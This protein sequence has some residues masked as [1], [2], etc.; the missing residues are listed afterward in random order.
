MKSK[1][2]EALRTEYV[3][4]GLS[5]KALDGVAG[6]LLATKTITDESQI[7]TAI[8]GAEIKD[9]L[10]GIQSEGDKAR[11][12]KADAE[13]ALNDYKLAHPETQ[14]PTNPPAPKDPPAPVDPKDPKG[15]LTLETLL[16]SFKEVAQSMVNP[17][18]ERLNKLDAEKATTAKL[19]GAMAL[20]EALK[21]DVTGQKAWIDDAWTEATASIAETDTPQAIVDRFKTRFDGYMTRLGANGYIPAAGSG[22]VEKS[23]AAKIVEAIE[24]E[25]KAVDGQAATVT[26]RLGLGKKD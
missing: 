12:A 8:K 19:Q 23:S 4:L 13:K 7:A 5:E 17:I 11:Q 18:Q 9:L 14:D 3:N 25:A 15:P 6:M 2:K 26:E 10:T 24:N 21:L 16:S 20:R 1:I 22:G